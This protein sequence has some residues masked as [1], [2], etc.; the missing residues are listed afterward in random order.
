MAQT[1]L[2]RGDRTLCLSQTLTPLHSPS[3]AI[4]ILQNPQ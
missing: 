1:N 2:T 4:L 3:S